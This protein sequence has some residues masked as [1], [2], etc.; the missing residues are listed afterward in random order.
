M[1]D[2]A[3]ST[4]QLLLS[5][6][7]AITLR[8]TKLDDAKLQAYIDKESNNEKQEFKDMMVALKV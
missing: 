8:K 7:R 3:S 6:E 2:E 5:T 1:I 4:D